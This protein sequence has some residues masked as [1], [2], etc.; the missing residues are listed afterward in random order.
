[1]RLDKAIKHMSPKYTLDALTT[2]P[3]AGN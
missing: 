2:Y 3:R 1:V